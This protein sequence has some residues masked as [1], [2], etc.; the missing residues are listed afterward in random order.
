MRGGGGEGYSG[1]DTQATLEEGNQAKIGGGCHV[2]TRGRE[3][4]RRRS[5]TPTRGGG[6][7]PRSFSPAASLST[8]AVFV[9]AAG[10]QGGGHT[11][12]PKRLLRHPVH[13]GRPPFVVFHRRPL[14]HVQHAARLLARNRV[15]E[16]LQRDS[17]R[18][19]R[20]R[21]FDA[22]HLHVD[23]VELLPTTFPPRLLSPRFRAPSEEHAAHVRQGKLHQDQRA[24][25]LVA[26][27]LPPR[28]AVHDDDVCVPPRLAP[29]FLR[30]AACVQHDARSPLS[31][32]G[33]RG[34]APHPHRQHV[35][36]QHAVDDGDGVAEGGCGLPHRQRAR[37]VSHEP[38]GGL[39]RST[40]AG[41]PVRRRPRAAVAAH[42]AC[43]CRGLRGGRRVWSRVCT[44]EC[45]CVAVYCLKK[46][47]MKYRY[48]SFY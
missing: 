47:P 27:E 35:E 10:R 42:L 30:R 13:H 14:K 46:K 36:T 44:D 26:R 5:S 31:R 9:A 11:P 22:F 8:P 7:S 43:S 3:D 6:V 45:L 33:R 4:R 34:A 41:A 21:V 12:A 23:F 40:S 1:S 32:E 17:V 15:E 20:A 16:R 38:V 29:A 25:G 19:Q 2:D 39:V 18:H 37:H 48:C 24:Q 28:Q